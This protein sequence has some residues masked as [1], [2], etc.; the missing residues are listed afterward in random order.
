MTGSERDDIS[1]LGAIVEVEVN[2]LDLR[3][4]LTSCRLP[5]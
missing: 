4:D 3:E 5:G 2:E 1:G